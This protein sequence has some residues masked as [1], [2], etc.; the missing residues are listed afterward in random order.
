MVFMSEWF[1]VIRWIGALYLVYRRPAAVAVPA[2]ERPGAPPSLPRS[3]REASM[4]EGVLVSLSNPRRAVVPRRVP[5]AVHRSAR[6]I[7]CGNC[8]C[9]PCC[10]SSCSPPWTWP[11]RAGG[12]PGTRHLLMPPRLALLDG[13]AGRPAAA[14]RPGPGDGAAAVVVAGSDPRVNV[15]AN[16][17]VQARALTPIHHETHRLHLRLLRSRHQRRTWT[18]SRA[19]RAWST[20]LVVGIGVHPGKAPLF[21]AEE[22]IEMLKSR[23]RGRSPSQDRLQDRD[24][25]LRQSDRR[26]APRPPA[27]PLIFRGLRDG[28]DFDYEMQMAGMNGTMAPGIDT[29][30]L[31]ASPGVRHITGDAGAAD[32]PDGRRRVTQFVSPAVPKRL[33]AKAGQEAD[34]SAR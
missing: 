13:A 4:C 26:C 18:S 6:A 12:G 11:I 7:R 30:F 23:D 20:R 22:K 17:N 10:S 2:A 27:R 14:R 28:T 3:S 1:D 5:A 25:H 8:R 34:V 31:P 19:Q 29:V 33:K 21:S 9:W 15:G 32:C 16:R 24:R